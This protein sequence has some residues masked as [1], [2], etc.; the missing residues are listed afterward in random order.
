MKNVWTFPQF[1]FL[2]RNALKRRPTATEN[3]IK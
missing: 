3:E 1:Y 2:F